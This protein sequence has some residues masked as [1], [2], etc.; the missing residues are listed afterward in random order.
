LSPDNGY[1]REPAL[2]SL[3]AL[4]D[5]EQL[6]A[7][8]SRENAVTTS[9]GEI[10]AILEGRDQSGAVVVTVDRQ[11]R[12]LDVTMSRWWREHLE[13]SALGAA[14]L[15]AHT[16]ATAKA[17]TAVAAAALSGDDGVPDRPSPGPGAW[18]ENADRSAPFGDNGDRQWLREVEYRLGQVGWELDRTE[19]MR[20]D[21]AAHA[22]QER[23]VSGPYGYV[24]VTLRGPTIVNVEVDPRGA[25]EAGPE[26]LAGDALEAFR[27]AG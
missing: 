27:A 1:G 6:Y 2:V 16:V 4:G 15:Q 22:E 13:P 21:A 9:G 3:D 14:L 18:P 11:G 5:P 8:A 20:E 26:R 23:A 25:V 7:A 24:R 12:A 19:R 17:L 10:G